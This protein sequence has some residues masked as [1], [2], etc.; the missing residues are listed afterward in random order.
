[1]FNNIQILTCKNNTTKVDEFLDRRK[2][3]FSFKDGN[4]HHSEYHFRKTS[5]FH[6]NW[7]LDIVTSKHIDKIQYNLIDVIIT[8]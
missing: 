4:N 6:S 5:Y 3:L 7:Y 1:M 8:I 2:E